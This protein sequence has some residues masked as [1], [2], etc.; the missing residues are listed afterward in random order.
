MDGVGQVLPSLL[1]FEESLFSQHVA[2]FTLRPG[3]VKTSFN[4]LDECD[5][6]NNVDMTSFVGR[7]GVQDNTWIQEATRILVENCNDPFLRIILPM[8]QCDEKFCS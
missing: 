2:A 4:H 8:T 1:V 6:K 3:A 5:N 7:I